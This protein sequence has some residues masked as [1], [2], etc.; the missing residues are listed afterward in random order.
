MKKETDLNFRRSRFLFK[1]HSY[2]LHFIVFEDSKK[3]GY[4]SQKIYEIG[5]NKSLMFQLSDKILKDIIRHE[6]GHLLT[7]LEYGEVQAHGNEYRK[8]CEKYGWKQDVMN[9]KIDLTLS[10]NFSRSLSEEKIYQ[11]VIKLLK[12][13][14]SSNIYEAELATTKA[15]ELI[16]NYNLK[17]ISL[18]SL[19]KNEEKI[20][21]CR[22]LEGK[23]STG[24][25]QAIYEILQDFYVAPVF[26]HYKSG[27]YLEITGTEFNVKLGEYVAHFLNHELDYL[28]ETNR[29]QQSL[30]GIREKNSFMRGVAKGMREKIKK[31]KVAIGN[32][33]DL[34]TIERSL[35]FYTDRVY[36]R[37]SSKAVSN[38]LSQRA[39]DSGVNAGKELTINPG[40][41]NRSLKNLVFIRKEDE[42]PKI[43]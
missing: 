17:S 10:E 38:S 19:D 7:W 12:L 34:I 8:T 4:F 14:S 5:I 13:S 16:I 27:F 29:K 31:Q 20:S 26:N 30:S 1:N 23:K 41:K 24:K 21:M 9:S 18:S 37:L 32:S 11:K 36:K 28:W 15:N 42:V 22:V 39:H 6:I 3:I 33:K 25:F 2:P 40:I 43:L 35:K